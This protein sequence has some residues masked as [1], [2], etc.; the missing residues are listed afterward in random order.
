MLDTVRMHSSL[1]TATKD[2]EVS[3]TRWMR[4]EQHDIIVQCEKFT[5]EIDRGHDDLPCT[6]APSNFRSRSNS[7]YSLRYGKLY[8]IVRS[9][10]RILM[11]SYF[12]KKRKS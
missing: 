11:Q 6:I 3:T 12:F 1:V 8:N 9:R 7:C 10:A 2:S 4:C 5:V